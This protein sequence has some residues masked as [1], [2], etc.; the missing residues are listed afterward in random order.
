MGSNFSF[1]RES[2]R[3]CQSL[4]LPVTQMEAL[5]NTVFFVEVE[6]EESGYHRG[7]AANGTI[8]VE[9]ADRKEYSYFTANTHTQYQ[10]LSQ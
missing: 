3:A 10:S 7:M 6:E 5:Q 1:T 8:T 9:A 2:G 4:S